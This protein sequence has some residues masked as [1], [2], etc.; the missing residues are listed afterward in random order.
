MNSFWCAH[1]WLDDEVSDDVR[2]TIDDGLI[3][4]VEHAVSPRADD[5]ILA[6]LVFPGF[7]NAHSHAFH[8]ALRG[9]TPSAAGGSFWTWRQQMYGL[10]ARLDPDTYHAL[11]RATYAEMVQTGICAVAEFHYLHH[12]PTGQPYADPNVM[13]EALRSAA[14]DAGIRLT[15]LDTCY[16]SGGL[17]ASG[18]RPLSQPQL[19]F[20]DGSVEGWVNRHEALRT[21]DVT[22]LGAAVH[23]LRAVPPTDLPAVVAASTGTPLHVHLSEQPGE[24]EVC[25]QAYG[26]SP[27]YLLAAAGA[28]GPDTVAV[29]ATHLTPEDLSLLGGAGTGVCLCPT[30]ERDLAD[31]IGRGRDLARSG[32]PLSVGSDS[33][34]VI[35]LIEEARG[36]ELH[37]RLRTG[38]RGHFSPAELV[39]MPTAGGYAALG[40][41]TGGTIRVGS[42]GDLVAVSTASVRTAGAALEELIL[43]ATAADVTDVVVGGEPV[44][45]AG[46][47]RLGDVGEALRVAIRDL[48]GD[49]VR[50]DSR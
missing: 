23:S 14:R 21:D 24:N 18:P 45:T 11:A 50:G 12:Q 43:A 33:H 22:V 3:T 32:S 7:A 39:R 37:E 44:V 48:T 36:V 49:P 29:H 15:L 41:P 40:R 10:A 42:L 28:L 1:A 31:G 47:H 26:H 9:R 8:R 2:V 4:A 30:T 17:D 25:Q 6:G 46:R 16:L 34:V 20:S 5:T 19:R 13:G 27:T 38:V 35:D